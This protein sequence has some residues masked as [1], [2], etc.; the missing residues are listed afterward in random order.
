MEKESRAIKEEAL[1]FTWWMRGGI[2][3][4]EAMALGPEERNVINQIIKDN[5]ETTKKSGMP[6]F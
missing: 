2:N 5:M 3:Y 4:N 6:F 1:R